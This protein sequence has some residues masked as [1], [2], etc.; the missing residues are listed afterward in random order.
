VSFPQHSWH[1]LISFFIS[2]LQDQLVILADVFV[3]GVSPKILASVQV[4][5]LWTLTAN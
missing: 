2:A 4:E 3:T 5:Q 1:L